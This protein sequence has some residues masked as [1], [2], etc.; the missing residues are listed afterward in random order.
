MEIIILIIFLFFLFS[1]FANKAKEKQSIED[2]K[3]LLNQEFDKEK[4]RLEEMI[5]K[6]DST[7]EKTETQD[8]LNDSCNYNFILTESVFEDIC[9]LLKD[10]CDMIMDICKESGFQNYILGIKSGNADID[11][12]Q[13]LFDSLKFFFIQDILRSYGR[14]GCSYYTNGGSGKKNCHIEFDTPEGQLLYCIVMQ[15]MKYDDNKCFTWEECKSD[16]NGKDQFSK[17]IRHT[18]VKALNTYANAD[19]KASAS[20][21]L[22][23]FAFCLIFH[24]YNKEYENTYRKNMFRIASI[25]AN[26]D[27]KVNETERQWL[28]SIMNDN[29]D[30]TL[31]LTED[32]IRQLFM[33]SYD[34]SINLWEERMRIIY[35]PHHEHSIDYLVEHKDIFEQAEKKHEQMDKENADRIDNSRLNFE[36]KIPQNIL[37][38]YKEHLKNIEVEYGQMFMVAS[39]KR[40]KTNILEMNLDNISVNISYAHFGFNNVWIDHLLEINVDT[41]YF[42][43]YPEFV[44]QS[45]ELFSSNFII[46]P[47]DNI[48]VEYTEQEFTEK[49]ERLRSG[50][51]INR[52]IYTDDN[53]NAPSIFYNG[54]ECPKKMYGI[55]TIKPL[56]II[57]FF[58]D[59]TEGSKFADAL[60]GY[61]AKY[62]RLKNVVNNN[63][64]NPLHDLIGL[65]KVK[66]EVTTLVNFIQMKQKRDEMGMKSPNISYHCVFTG[67]PGTGK[68]TVARILARIYKDLGILKSGHLVE[69]DRSGLVA[70]Y[71]GQT[72]VKTNK[73]I[74]KALDGVLFIDEAYTL[75]QG[76]NEDY[77]RE[78]IATLL[79]RME[80]N[81]DRLVVILAGY[82]NEI[83]AFINSNPGL[84]SRFNRYIHF[85]DYTAEELFEIFTLQMKK[86]EYTLSDDAEQYLKEKL[87]SVVANKPK[88][89]GNA[90]YIRNLFEKS[91]EKQANRLASLAEPTKQ[92]LSLIKKEDII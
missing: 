79:K 36:T 69:V 88:D 50:H 64:H 78:A 87:E 65:H 77:G 33:K 80:D 37:F 55:I 24:N 92:D 9:H 42:Y 70:E 49:I 23:D 34:A 41:N 1:Y 4:K 68:T 13:Q 7:V 26:A 17:Q 83:E 85:E 56:G 29:T 28:D 12:S 19:V 90:R 75:A 39:K 51:E 22:D 8:T 25:I 58:K 73:T 27:G 59:T 84:R 46:Y 61:I 32:T 5:S 43:F 40:T 48:N 62:K 30:T 47:M 45:N 89:F 16:I 81:R 53:Q 76:G 35:Q 86:N 66:K 60:N 2:T 72:A 11:N 3:N 82:T 31:P 6:K 71:V 15:M 63:T 44:I 14:M 21:G 54:I 18:A 67:N 74:D 52:F 38:L 10:T 20:N 91:I 57:L